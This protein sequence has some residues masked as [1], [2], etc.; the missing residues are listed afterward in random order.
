M[1]H[2]LVIGAHARKLWHY[3]TLFGMQVRAFVDG[4]RQASGSAQIFPVCH[5][6]RQVVMVGAAAFCRRDRQRSCG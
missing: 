3:A 4:N 2:D 6:L 5:V 1:S